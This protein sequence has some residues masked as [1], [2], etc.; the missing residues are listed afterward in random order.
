MNLVGLGVI[1]RRIIISMEIRRKFR[2]ELKVLET[3]NWGGYFRKSW[4]NH[5]AGHMSKEEKNAIYLDS[6]LWHL[7]SCDAF[8]RTGKA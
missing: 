6:F 7:C 8:S 4:E 5:F 3:F 2:K 1:I